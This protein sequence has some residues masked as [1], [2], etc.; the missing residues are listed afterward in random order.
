MV[1]EYDTF[2]NS[3]STPTWWWF[4]AVNSS[5]SP[6]AAMTGPCSVSAEGGGGGG[7]T[8]GND[9]GCTMLGTI[10]PVSAGGK[11]DG[12]TGRWRQRRTYWSGTATLMKQRTILAVVLAHNIACGRTP[13]VGRL[14]IV[15]I[16]VVCT[17][18][19]KTSSYR[20]TPRLCDDVKTNCLKRT[21]TGQTAPVCYVHARIHTD[22]R[23]KPL[24]DN[25][26]WRLVIPTT[27]RCQDLNNKMYQVN[28]DNRYLWLLR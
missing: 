17:E 6:A 19:F 1:T 26:V 23:P 24:A 28:Y 16:V 21:N 12:R 15:V 27:T 13:K 4:S 3:M 25:V 2:E 5:R 20:Q 18:R 10:Y 22:R 9:T 14:S 11:D 7:G 8:P